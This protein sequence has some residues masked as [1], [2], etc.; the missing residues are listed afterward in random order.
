MLLH[1]A[2][3]ERPTMPQGS[4]RET[5][6]PAIEAMFVILDAGEYVRIRYA[7]SSDPGHISD[8]V[9]VP[10][11]LIQGV[12]GLMLRAVQV[13][14]EYGTRAF[15]VPQIL[16]AR[17]AGMQLGP[18]IERA[19]EF[20]ERIVMHIERLDP[21]APNAKRTADGVVSS[22]L[23]AVPCAWNE[24]WFRDYLLGLRTALI[25]GRLSD[26]EASALKAL[27]QQLHLDFDRIVAVHSYLLGQE[28]LAISVDGIAGTQE[29]EYLAGIAT[30]LAQLGWP[31]KG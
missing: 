28:M 7:K 11:K 6:P 20:R 19:A 5:F 8:R 4:T 25:D 14:P 27:Q 3:S 15:K 17:P 21:S 16:E 13:Q 2:S 1:G 24:P 31:T 12:E 22:P 23:A 9:I 29:R 26:Q 10:V 18:A 30:G